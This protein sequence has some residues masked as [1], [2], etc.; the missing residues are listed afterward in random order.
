MQEQLTGPNRHNIEEKTYG[1]DGMDKLER[2]KLMAT[3]KKNR[4]F[5]Q[6]YETKRIF[7]VSSPPISI[8]R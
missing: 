6:A 1:F 4:K 8:R 3:M 5:A 7:F 2:E